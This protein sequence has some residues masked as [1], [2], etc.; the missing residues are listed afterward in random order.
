MPALTDEEIRRA[1]GD[2]PPLSV[3]RRRPGHLLLDREEL[4]D[5]LEQRGYDRE[6]AGDQIEAWVDAV[7]GKTRLLSSSISQGPRPGRRNAPIPTPSKIV[8]EIPKDRL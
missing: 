3:G 5:G 1:V 2:A 7:G 6:E 8:L 4:L